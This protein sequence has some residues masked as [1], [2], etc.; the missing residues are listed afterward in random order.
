MKATG[1]AL[2]VVFSK[3]TTIVAIVRALYHNKNYLFLSLSPLFFYLSPF[4]FPTLFTALSN[5]HTYGITNFT[6]F[7]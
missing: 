4:Y 3:D 2:V 6:L 5:L 1:I 7:L